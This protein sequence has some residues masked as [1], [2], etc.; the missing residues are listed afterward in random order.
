MLPNP[1]HPH[2]LRAVAA[3]C[4]AVLL[5]AIA[6]LVRSNAALHHA[7]ASIVTST[8]STNAATHGTFALVELFTSEGCSSCPS[9]DKLVAEL[10]QDAQSKRTNIVALC[11][12][13]DYWNSLGWKDRFSSK[14]YSDRQRRYAEV[15]KGD[16]VYTPQMIV[17]GRE[18][19]VGSDRARA[20]NAIENALRSAPPL[21]LQVQIQAS[22]RN[23]LTVRYT[24][25]SVPSG[26]VV[27][28]AIVEPHAE[29]NVMRGEN[30]GR[31]L[32]HVNVVRA[33]ASVSMQ[34]AGEVRLSVEGGLPAH[35]TVVAFAQHTRTMDVLG[36]EQ[37]VVQ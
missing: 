36:V 18:E 32:A 20:T 7:P 14:A 28:V 12:H 27:N 1:Q 34:A 22:S 17:N 30:A 8:T 19:F 25:S 3:L 35:S 37:V 11:F 2:Y 13:V 26:A 24:A 29:S 15:L 23:K 31:K 21:A 9:A 5:M 6:L 33:F 4:S 10:V 16:G